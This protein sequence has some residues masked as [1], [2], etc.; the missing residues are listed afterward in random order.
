VRA[1]AA[2]GE[3]AVR[4]AE[5]AAYIGQCDEAIQLGRVPRILV[6]GFA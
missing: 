6:G 5:A 4:R 1:G 2:P 3:L